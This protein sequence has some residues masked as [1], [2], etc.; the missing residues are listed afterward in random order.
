MGPDD[1]LPSLVSAY[2]RLDDLLQAAKDKPITGGD[3]PGTMFLPAVAVY[4]ELYQKMSVKTTEA[5]EEKIKTTTNN[6]VQKI[7]SKLKALEFDWN[8]LLTTVDPEFAESDKKIVKEGEVV[9]SPVNLVNARTGTQTDLQTLLSS[10]S[11][12]YLHLILLRYLSWPPWRDHVAKLE[13][14]LT[15]LSE[16]GCKVALVSFGTTQSSTSWLAE[17]G[18]NLDMYV[19]KDRALYKMLGQVRSTSQ[20][21]NIDTIKYVAIMNIHGRDLPAL[22]DDDVHDDLQMGGNMTIRCDDAKM[23][24]PYPSKGATDRPTVLQILKKI[25]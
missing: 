24:M 5:F 2:D 25:G 12:S 15:L 8:M 3:V 18:S 9:P 10:S 22:I 7:L 21:Y 16:A 19:D 6:E 20:V 23:I 4:K 14:E 17:T 13:K 1:L 11:S